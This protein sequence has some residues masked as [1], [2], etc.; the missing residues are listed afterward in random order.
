MI[1]EI[2]F[3]GSSDDTFQWEKSID[4]KES[5]WDSTDDCA[6][7]TRRAYRVTS[8]DDPR[9]GFIITG[10]Y[11]QNDQG[12]WLIG[13]QPLDFAEDDE[14]LYPKWEVSV[15]AAERNYSTM[16][17]IRADVD[18]DVQLLRSK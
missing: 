5:D 8:K 12:T 7:F 3:Y 18:V 6:T 4:G 14:E 1:V 13:I 15:V 11:A 9:I 17:V 2:K 10:Q 16:M